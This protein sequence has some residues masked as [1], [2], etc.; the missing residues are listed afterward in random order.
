LLYD[1]AHAHNHTLLSPTYC[2]GAQIFVH[3]GIA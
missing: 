2:C 3:D 1:Q